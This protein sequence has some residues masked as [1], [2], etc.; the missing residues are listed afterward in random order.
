MFSV[1]ICTYNNVDLLGP[2]VLKLIE[3]S[4]IGEI[5]IID[6]ASTD[7]TKSFL[8]DISWAFSQD[9]PGGLIEVITNKENLG[10][11]KSRNQGLKIA[12]CEF[13]MILDDD[14]LPTVNHTFDKYISALRHFDIVGYIPG[15]ATPEVGAIVVTDNG[16]FNHVGEG[17]ICMKTELWKRIGYFNEEFHPAYR[18]G[19]DLQLRSL[20]LGIKIGCIRDARI[21]HFNNRTLGKNNLLFNIKEVGDRSHALFMLKL[22]NGTYGSTYLYRGKYF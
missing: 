8:K 17:G 2:L 14:Q 20:Q 13:S 10:V 15:L 19:P 21:K 5:V 3:E 18:E 22:H 12:K 4:L 9:M 16:P 1:I 7:G 11:I 6:N